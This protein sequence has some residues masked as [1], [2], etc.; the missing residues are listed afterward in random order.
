MCNCFQP[1]V[2]STE[3]WHWFLRVALNVPEHMEFGLEVCRNQS[4][5]K[6]STSLL[7]IRLN[8]KSKPVQ[9]QWQCV[10]TLFCLFAEDLRVSAAEV[11]ADRLVIGLNPP[12][13]KNAS[14]ANEFVT[15]AVEK[16]QPRMLVLIVPP[17][18]KVTES[19][20][21]SMA[22]EAIHHIIS[23]F[24]PLAMHERSFVYDAW[25]CHRTGHG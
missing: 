19:L 3:Y 20:K 6:S 24:R 21:F 7:K 1:V 4:L 10:I 5:Q 9:L 11:S 23:I 18:T 16:F 2:D 15:Y 14:L 25:C 17:I 13:G 12:F 22:G 8:T